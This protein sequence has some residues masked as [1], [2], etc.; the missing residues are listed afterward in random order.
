MRGFLFSL[1]IN[2]I[3]ALGASMAYEGSCNVPVSLVTSD[4]GLDYYSFN[5]GGMMFTSGNSLIFF[6]RRQC[7]D[8]SR[9]VRLK[10]PPDISV[11]TTVILCKAISM[12]ST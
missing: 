10:Y 9:V 1:D 2:K 4:G 3:A 6:R 5:T 11:Y 7:P 12:S 8:A